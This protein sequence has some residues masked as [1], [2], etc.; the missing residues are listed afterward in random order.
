MVLG[1]L[2]LLATLSSLSILGIKVTHATIG[3]HIVLEPPLP[4]RPQL[5]DCCAIWLRLTR[6]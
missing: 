4:R 6:H 2:R 1:V 5:V 3:G